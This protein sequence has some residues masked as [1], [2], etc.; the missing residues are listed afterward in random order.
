M[1][2]KI[3]STAIKLW[4][5]SQVE[6]TEKLTIKINS[7]NRQIL[8]GYIPSVYLA[9][10]YVIYQ[11][12]H[13]HQVKLQGFNLRVNLNQ[14][15]KGEALRLL[16]AVKVEGNVTFEEA[17]LQASLSSPLLLSGL[18]DLLSEILA[19][20]YIERPQQKLSYYSFDWQKI[21]LEEE[22][23]I[24]AGTMKCNHNQQ[25]NKINIRTGLTLANSHTLEFFPLHLEGLSDLFMLEVD[26]LSIDLGSEVVIEDLILEPGKLFCVGGLQIMP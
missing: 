25:I 10:D 8:G 2:S 4:L 6:K 16:E 12:L 26:R 21:L 3:V 20:N 11:G 24:I 5:K 23:I 13:L 7:G 14:I 18:R 1:I 19:A 15:I 17:S 22:K 9:S